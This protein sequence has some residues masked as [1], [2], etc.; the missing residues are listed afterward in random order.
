MNILK[1][2]NYRNYLLGR[3]ITNYGD[4]MYMQLIIIYITINFPNE[5]PLLLTINKILI[6]TV[7][8]L[9]LI[10]GPFIDSIKN[11]VKF[12]VILESSLLLLIV[13]STYLINLKS[14]SLLLLVT[15]IFYFVNNIKQITEF[16]IKKVMIKNDDLVAFN[17][18]YRLSGTFFDTIANATSALIISSLG[19]IISSIIN[20]ITFILSINFFSQLKIDT[21][22]LSEDDSNNER[23]MKQYYLDIKIGFREFFSAKEFVIIVLNDALLNGP[24]MLLAVYIPVYLMEVDKLYLYPVYLFSKTIGWFLATLFSEKIL[25]LFKKNKHVFI[26]DYIFNLVISIIFLIT[27]S[28]EVLI[29]LTTIYSIPQA[30]TGILYEP[31][32]LNSYRTET[33]G[34]IGTIISL[35]FSLSMLCFLILSIVLSDFVNF[36]SIFSVNVVF[37]IITVFSLHF[38]RI[39]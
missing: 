16:S 27:Q 11:K 23:G 14:L 35:F 13:I 7:G 24:A 1:N 26:F 4:S 33:I 20:I 28:F 2:K 3:T 10:M 6:V 29:V 22:K 21:K 25:K 31:I 12:L 39:K 36:T 5:S 8:I 34:R 30:L 9:I 19:F 15:F 38:I 17:K 32:A 18:Y 37:T